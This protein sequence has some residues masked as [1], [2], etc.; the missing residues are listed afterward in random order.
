MRFSLK[1]VKILLMPD[2]PPG[3]SGEVASSTTSFLAN[4]SDF[5]VLVFGVLL[6][7]LVVTI[8]VR[9]LHR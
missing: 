2:F 6:A 9:S 4:L 7:A 8:I 1:L 5:L 3:F